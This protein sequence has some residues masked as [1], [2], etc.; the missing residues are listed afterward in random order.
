MKFR[1]SPLTQRLSGIW[2][3]ESVGILGRIWH[4]LLDFKTEF[5]FRPGARRIWGSDKCKSASSTQRYLQHK[6]ISTHNKNEY[7]F[8]N[9]VSKKHLL[10][11]ASPTFSHY[12]TAILLCIAFSPQINPPCPS[13]LFVPGLINTVGVMCN[14]VPTCFTMNSIL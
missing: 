11:W 14:N 8:E 7:V 9:L 4:F 1:I 10:F 12:C 2:V 5:H 6:H 13:F 3:Y